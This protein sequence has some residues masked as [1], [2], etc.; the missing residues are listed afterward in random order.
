MLKNREHQYGLIARLLHWVLAL[1]LAGLFGLGW[2]M[3]GLTYYDPWYHKSIDLHKALGVVTAIVILVRIGWAVIDTK[4]AYPTALKPWEKSAANAVHGVL[5]LLMITIPVS[6]YLISTAQGHGISMFGLF[7]IPALLPA[8]ES[9]EEI[10]GQVH[11]FLAF[12]GS[13]VVLMHA[14]AAFKHNLIDRVDILG[15][16]IGK[17]KE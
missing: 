8:G 12:G 4:P 13:W 11:Y 16:M 15:R 9:R 5:Y 2:Y 10:A 7:E 17:I 14:G 6:G 1:M 3:T